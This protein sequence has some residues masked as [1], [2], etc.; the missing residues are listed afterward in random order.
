M[1]RAI[2]PLT[3]T[4]AGIR[5]CD[6]TTVPSR[7]DATRTSSRRVPVHFVSRSAHRT[8]GALRRS[9]HA[10]RR[11]LPW[12]CGVRWG[13][14]RALHRLTDFG[15]PQ[16][17]VTTIRTSNCTGQTPQSAQCRRRLCDGP[18]LPGAPRRALRRVLVPRADAEHR[19]PCWRGKRWMREPVGVRGH[20]VGGRLPFGG[21]SSRQLPPG[22]FRI[23]RPRPD[24][25]LLQRREVSDVPADGPEAN[26]VL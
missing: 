10:W 19:A 21:S 3:R 1:P 26:N 18:G 24:L 2:S 6:T 9:T 22:A 20:S 7:L 17:A 12:L 14:L 5:W 8:P 25:S 16:A 15:V 4:D 11:L 23:G 13:G